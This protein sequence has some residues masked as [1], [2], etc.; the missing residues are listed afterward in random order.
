[1][2]AIHS[3]AQPRSAASSIMASGCKATGSEALSDSAPPRS[4]QSPFIASVAALIDKEADGRTLA[5]RVVLTG[6]L[7]MAVFICQH[8]N[9]AWLAKSRRRNQEHTQNG[10]DGKTS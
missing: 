8:L 6:N 4:C 2:A 7:E 3:A 1:M 5:V 9:N 10:R